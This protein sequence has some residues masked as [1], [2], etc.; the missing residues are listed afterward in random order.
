MANVSQTSP[1]V[2]QHQGKFRAPLCLIYIDSCKV[3]YC[4]VLAIS[5]E[6]CF[7]NFD[8]L[9]VSYAGSQI[10]VITHHHHHWSLPLQLRL[11]LSGIPITF[12]LPR[13]HG[14]FGPIIPR[15]RIIPLNTLT[16]QPTKMNASADSS[17]HP[18]KKWSIHALVFSYNIDNKKTMAVRSLGFVTRALKTKKQCGSK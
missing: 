6:R 15:R 11:Y 1:N 13:R 18:G 7:F 8:A 2:L 10:S 9:W 14:A 16:L 3:L 4:P 12:A 17:V 5:T